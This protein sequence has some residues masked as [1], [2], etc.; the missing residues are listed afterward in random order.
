MYFHA[1]INSVENDSFK[2]SSTETFANDSKF[3]S[4]LHNILYGLSIRNE[5][6]NQ[7][8]AIEN[9]V[10]ANELFVVRGRAAG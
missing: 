10:L 6:V 9:S 2:K 3:L 1:C 7:T 8:D 4:P 5:A